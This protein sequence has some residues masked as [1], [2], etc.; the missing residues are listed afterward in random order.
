MLFEIAKNANLEQ[1]IRQYSKYT[2]RE[3]CT[4]ETIYK[5]HKR[6][7]WMQ[8]RMLRLK[9][10][11]TRYKKDTDRFAYDHHTQGLLYGDRYMRETREWKSNQIHST[12]GLESSQPYRV[13]MMWYC[14]HICYV[15]CCP[16]FNWCWFARKRNLLFHPC[17]LAAVYSPRVKAAVKIMKTVSHTETFSMFWST[18]IVYTRQYC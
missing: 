2:K 1:C 18:K 13:F 11:W 8:V 5:R 4:A 16:K 7:N 6:V 15:Y 10:R 17:S 12:S 14:I 3:Q 9:Q